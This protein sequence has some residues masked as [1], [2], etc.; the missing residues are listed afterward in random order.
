MAQIQSGN[1]QLFSHRRFQVVLL[2]VPPSQRQPDQLF[3]FSVVTTNNK[4]QNLSLL[5]PSDF[6]REVKADRNGV[7]PV[8]RHVPRRI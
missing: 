8:S 7:R 3:F 6:N 5:T 1:R 2:L 4:G